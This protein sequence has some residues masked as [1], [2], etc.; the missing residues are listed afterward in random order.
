MKHSKIAII[1]AGRVGTTTAYALMLKNIAAQILLV[2]VDPIRCKGE[3]LD[4][5]DA[6]PFCATS[7]IQN[8]TLED[9]AQS[10]II[11]ITA[12]IAQKPGQTRVELLETN[13]KVMDSI[14]Q[15][16]TPLNPN[17][18]IIVVSNPLDLL[19]LHLYNK[20][21]INPKQ[22]FGA[23]TFLDSIRLTGKIATHF[24]I[25]PD[26]VHAWIL[27]EHGDNQ[28]VAWSSV[29]CDGTPISSLDISQQ[30]LDQLAQQTKQKAYDIIECK[31]STFYGIATC[32]ATLCES[33]VFNQRKIFPLSSYQKEYG[34]F[35]S[36]PSVLGE[37]GIEEMFP[38][39]LNEA[40]KKQ[41]VK[42]ADSLKLK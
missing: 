38:L 7:C 21:L 29:M 32:V 16:L 37:H 31:G 40:E 20:K 30:E 19:A 1:G 26:S 5:E 23:G 2:D 25:A 18:I 11:I 33:I 42:S 27:G 35:M 4:L 12:G 6:I 22:L 24:N 41:L 36:M 13:K 8:A 3:F 14:A 9:A 17:A 10:D 39:V 34:V 15:G 28:F